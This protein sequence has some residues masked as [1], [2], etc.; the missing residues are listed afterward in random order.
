MPPDNI[1]KAG[2]LLCHSRIRLVRQRNVLVTY[3]V[4]NGV[5]SMGH[6]RVIVAARDGHVET[7]TS[8]R[9]RDL[10]IDVA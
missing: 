5:A 9:N 2:R 7:S 4:V 3:E 10:G 6:G 8:C 1:V